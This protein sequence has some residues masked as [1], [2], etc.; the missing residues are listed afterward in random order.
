MPE[1]LL[2]DTLRSLQAAEL[3][4]ETHLFPEQTYTYTHALTQEVAYGSL[5]HERRRTV[6]AQVA[7]ALERLYA[8]RWLDRVEQLAHHAFRGELWDKAVTYGRQAGEKALA[9]SAYREAVG[10]FEQALDA[11]Q[12]LPAQRATREQAIDLRLALRTALFPSGNMERILALLHEAESLALALEDPRRLVQV[13][14]FLSNQFRNLGTY[15]QAIA[16]GQ[17]ALALA[18]AAGDVLLQA[19]A[20]QFLGMAY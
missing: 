4:Y 14:V 17:R 10:S 18:T 9:R 13:S 16:V 8:D 11:L 3:L 12:H 5:L 20:N 1:D 15:D 6:H 7:D 19:L 2:M